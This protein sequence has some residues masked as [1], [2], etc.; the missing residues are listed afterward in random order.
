M[1]YQLAINP[2]IKA[3]IIVAILCILN[4]AI[5]LYRKHKVARF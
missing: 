3:F 2:S 1:F 4:V 5:D